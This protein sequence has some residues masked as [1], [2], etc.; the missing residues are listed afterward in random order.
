MKRIDLTRLWHNTEDDEPLMEYLEE[1]DVEN[2]DE[3]RR[4]REIRAAARSRKIKKRGQ[5]E[6]P[7]E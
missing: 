1:C 5:H 2:E 7:A 6:R 4:S 3:R